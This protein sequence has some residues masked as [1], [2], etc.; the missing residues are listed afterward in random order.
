MDRAEETRKF[1]EKVEVLNSRFTLPYKQKG[2]SRICT[3]N[4][5]QLR[6]PLPI[7]FSGKDT[8]VMVGNMLRNLE[9]DIVLLQECPSNFLSDVFPFH[10]YDPDTQLAVGSWYQ[11]TK[12]HASTYLINDFI[13]TNVHFDVRDPFTAFRRM[14][15]I[16]QQYKEQRYFV[17]GDCNSSEAVQWFAPYNLNRCFVGLT[18]WAGTEVDFIFTNGPVHKSFVAPVTLSDHLPVVYDV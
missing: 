12:L 7:D 3:F 1:V 8:T 6:S 17:A 2:A 4:V 11:L 18:C 14:S 5:H 13:L 16:F 9:V 10:D 15:S